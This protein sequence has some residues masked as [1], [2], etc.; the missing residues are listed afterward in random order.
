MKKE[1]NKR[2]SIPYSNST[3]AAPEDPESRRELMRQKTDP[4]RLEQIQ[5]QRAQRNVNFQMDD[6][7]FFDFDPNQ[8]MAI[9]DQQLQAVDETISDKSNGYSSANFGSKRKAQTIA[10]RTEQL[11]QSGSSSNQGEALSRQELARESKKD[12][13]LRE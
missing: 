11:Q 3:V 7:N 12:R 5:H 1:Q 6:D 4:S 13:F 9:H 10:D 2:R 8:R